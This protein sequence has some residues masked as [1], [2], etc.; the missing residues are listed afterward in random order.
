MYITNSIERGNTINSFLTHSSR[1]YENPIDEM[2]RQESI[3]TICLNS[4]ERDKG[5]VGIG[6]YKKKFGH[7]LRKSMDSTT[8]K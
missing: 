2:Q 3:E 6:L 5:K 8:R 7:R 4:G 1:P